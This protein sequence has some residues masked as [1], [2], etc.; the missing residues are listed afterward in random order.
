MLTFMSR[1]N[2]ITY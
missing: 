1:Y 2:E